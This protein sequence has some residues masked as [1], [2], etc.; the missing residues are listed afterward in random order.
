MTDKEYYGLY[1]QKNDV[2]IFNE[3]WWLDAVCGKEGWDAIVIGKDKKNFPEAVFPYSV[4]S[5]GAGKVVKMP[6]LTPYFMNPVIYNPGVKQYG[7]LSAE[8]NSQKLLIAELEKLGLSQFKAYFHYDYI[9]WLPFYWNQYSQSIRYT[10]VLEGINDLTRTWEQVISGS[11]K[12]S[13][14]KAEKMLSVHKVED[15]EVMYGLIAKT[16]ERQQMATPYDLSF[17]INLD[18]ALAE[19]R[20]RQILVAKDSTGA[21]HA[22]VYLVWDKH[23]AYYLA[24]GADPAFRDSGAK[25]LVLWEAIKSSAEFVDRFDFE[26]SMVENIEHF[27]STFGARQKLIFSISKSAPATNGRLPLASRLKK[28]L[29][30]LINK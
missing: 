25:T 26:G 21:V 15:P 12:T 8:R 29:R 23:S 7:R 9:N 24:G 13:V 3:P 5:F 11:V 30:V 6:L 16:F 28:A 10:Y 17:F 18:R 2:L 14:R 22:G 1:C 19:R 20:R 27:F 4:R